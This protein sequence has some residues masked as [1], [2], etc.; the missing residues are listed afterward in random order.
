MLLAQFFFIKRITERIFIEFG[1]S[2]TKTEAP[3][4]CEAQ[5]SVRLNKVASAV[6][7]NRSSRLHYFKVF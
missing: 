4:T 3:V 5:D 1:I 6:C 2:G 7:F